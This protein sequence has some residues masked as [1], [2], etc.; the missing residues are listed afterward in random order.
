M[1]GKDIMG[2]AKQFFIAVI[3]GALL[4]YSGYFIYN[5]YATFNGK[6]Y[7]TAKSHRQVHNSGKANI[8]TVFP[9]KVCLQENNRSAIIHTRT[10]GGYT[11]ANLHIDVYKVLTAANLNC[12][13][14]NRKFKIYGEWDPINNVFVAYSVLDLQSQ[15][16]YSISKLK[17]KIISLLLVIAGIALLISVVKPSSK[18]KPNIQYQPHSY[19]YYY[20]QNYRYY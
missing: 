15:Q 5:T 1:I 12:L 13:K 2:K 6:V 7:P 8:R 9:D 18:P 16:S 19:Y 20:Q 14:E 4:I 3:L 10:I 11:A 17:E